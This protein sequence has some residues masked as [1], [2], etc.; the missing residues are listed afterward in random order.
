[1]FLLIW[2]NKEKFRILFA[3]F[4]KKFSEDLKKNFEKICV[5]KN[6]VLVDKKN[7]KQIKKTLIN[8]S[9]LSYQNEV[10]YLS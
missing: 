9:Y 1:M 2:M 6:I 8:S 4:D 5:N 7:L 10:T 3:K